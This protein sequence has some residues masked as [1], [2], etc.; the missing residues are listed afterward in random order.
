MLIN[1]RVINIEQEQLIDRI[2]YDNI[3][4]EYNNTYDVGDYLIGSYIED[5]NCNTLNQC[6]NFG[7]KFLIYTSISKRLYYKYNFNDLKNYCLPSFSSNSSNEIISYFD[8]LWSFKRY[9]RFG[10]L[11]VVEQYKYNI[12]KSG[13]IWRSQYES[14]NY[15]VD[16][17]F[18]LR[19][20]QR[21]WK[22]I[23]KKKRNYLMR[24]IINLKFNCSTYNF[25]Q[26]Y[27]D[28]NIPTYRGCLSSL[29]N[30]FNEQ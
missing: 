23:F 24:K 16:K 15:I 5:T 29:K 14:V 17:T 7:Y 11:K 30:N 18:W 4:H 22:N 9:I 13:N 12:D 8:N 1:N 21:V 2:G 20:I 28:Y 10:I 3:Q 6:Y 19:L 27:Y 25:K 26:Q